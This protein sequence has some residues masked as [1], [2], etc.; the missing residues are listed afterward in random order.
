[1]VVAVPLAVLFG[2]V[3]LPSGRHEHA[4]G[5]SA[6]RTGLALPLVLLAV[7]IACYVGSE[8]GVSNWLVR[9]LDAASLTLATSALALFW[10]C[11]ALGRLVSARLSDRFDH[12]WFAAT[13]AIAASAALVAAVLVPSLPTSIVLFGVVGF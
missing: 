10:A 5:A 7:A 6:I 13:C 4:P 2:L 9:Y 11:L 3:R 8:I 1:A 12:A